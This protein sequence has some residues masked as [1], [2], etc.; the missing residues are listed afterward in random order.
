MS[1]G[2]ARNEQARERIVRFGVVTAVDP[3][4][5]RARVS[6]GGE[7]ESAWLSWFPL[8]AGEISVWAPPSEGE[9]VMVLS[10]SGDTAQGVII[11]SAFSSS[12]PP[13]AEAGGLFKIQVGASSIEI[14]A[15]GIRLS[16]PR[17]DLN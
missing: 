9:Q 11:G 16:A 2:A 8:R 17:I 7:T 1:Y 15:S 12:N 13:T 14:D 5:A 10:E 6:F 3:G 4:A